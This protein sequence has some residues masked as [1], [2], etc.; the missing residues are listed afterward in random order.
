MFIRNYRRAVF[1]VLRTVFLFAFLT[2]VP[3]RVALRDFLFAIYIS[4]LFV[5]LLKILQ[6]PLNICLFP[7]IV[8]IVNNLFI[9]KK[10]F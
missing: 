2:T 3:L 4:L 7:T 9:C 5:G 10:Y 1:F 6:N 8:N